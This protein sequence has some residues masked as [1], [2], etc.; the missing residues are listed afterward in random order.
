MISSARRPGCHKSRSITPR[1]A[2]IANDTSDAISHSGKSCAMAR[3]NDSCN[4]ECRALRR[5]SR[6][7][8]R[9]RGSSSTRI[10]S[11]AASLADR[12][13]GHLWDVTAFR[14]PD[15]GL[16]DSRL[17][18]QVSLAPAALDAYRPDRG[19]EPHVF[20]LPDSEPGLLPANY[21]PPESWARNWA[22]RGSDWPIPSAAAC[23][24]C[25]RI[26][27]RKPQA[28]TKAAEDSP[29]EYLADSR[30][31]GRAAG[32]SGRAAG[33]GPP[34]PGGSAAPEPR[35]AQ[36]RTHVLLRYGGNPVHNPP[37]HRGHGTTRTW[38][39]RRGTWTRYDRAWKWPNH[40]I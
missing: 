4:A 39:T 23:S 12:G 22:H 37:T 6:S 40:H 25:T 19:S 1:S 20:H 36:N 21:S 18:G 16:R 35:T 2:Q 26:P 8:P 17:R 24:A 34:R 29:G 7:A 38:T 10:S 14:S 5:R 31:S 32:T 13:Q 15:R 33:T 30:T 11:A 28:A 27:Y 3:T 9:P